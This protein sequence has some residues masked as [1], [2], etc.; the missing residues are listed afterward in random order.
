MA[1]CVCVCVCV[2][3]Y[4]QRSW[5]M[6]AV[7][8]SGR[9]GCRGCVGLLELYPRQDLLHTVLF[10]MFYT[11][12]DTLT[13]EFNLDD[14]EPMCLC[15]CK[16]NTL[17]CIRESNVEVGHLTKTRRLQEDNSLCLLADNYEVS[18]CVLDSHVMCVLRDNTHTLQYIIITSDSVNNNSKRYTH[19]H[20]GVQS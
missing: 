16:S 19:T 13:L 2:C 8:L 12:R 18:G 9:L 10:Q 6:W 3:V 20:T 5:D 14:I 11:Q 4:R 15:V 7:T 1:T 17:G